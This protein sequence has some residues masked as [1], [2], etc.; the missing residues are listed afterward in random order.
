MRGK[1]NQFRTE[2]ENYSFGAEGKSANPR[3]DLNDLLQRAKDEKR[4]EKKRISF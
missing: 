2:A 4:N 1:V 3:L